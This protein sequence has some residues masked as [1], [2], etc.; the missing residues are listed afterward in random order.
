MAL[1]LA[2]FGSTVRSKIL[3]RVRSGSV[4]DYSR[5][6]EFT[7]SSEEPNRLPSWMLAKSLYIYLTSAILRTNVCCHGARRSS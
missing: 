2:V 5:E 4:L 3:L 7:M 1:F 6:P